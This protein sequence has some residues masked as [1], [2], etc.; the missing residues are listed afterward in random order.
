MRYVSLAA[1]VCLLFSTGMAT[2]GT[3]VQGNV[4]DADLGLAGLAKSKFKLDG[5]GNYQFG[6]KEMTDSAGNPAAVTTPGNEYI[7]VIKGDAAGA[8][9]E[10][11]IQVPIA[12]E[13]QA[14]VKGSAA[15]LL[16]LVPVGTPVGV[17]G[18]EVHEPPTAPDAAACA[19]NLANGAPFLIGPGVWLSGPNPCASGLRIGYSGVV[20]EAP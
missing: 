20:T 4:V 7:A 16:G 5:K 9:W 10:L 3:K 17:S 11:N 18:A 8:L 14:K 6:L 19:A 1:A 12:K 2:A 13:G 15:A